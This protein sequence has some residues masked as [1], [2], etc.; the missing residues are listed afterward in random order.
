VVLVVIVVVM[1]VTCAELGLVDVAY[2]LN[3]F[4]NKYK[5]IYKSKV[6]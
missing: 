6:V 1:V 5:I 4:N 2:M 3:Y